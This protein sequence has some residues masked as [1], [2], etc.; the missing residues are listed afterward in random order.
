[1]L[2]TNNNPHLDK[3]SIKM[4]K[5]KLPV[6]LTADESTPPIMVIPFSS[7]SITKQRIMGRRKLVILYYFD[8][9]AKNKI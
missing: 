8:F 7:E 3:M 4:D 1:V 9:V 6:L 2:F 5:S